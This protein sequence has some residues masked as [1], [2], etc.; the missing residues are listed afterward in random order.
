MPVFLSLFKKRISARL[1][2]RI[3]NLIEGSETRFLY[4]IGDL[5]STPKGGM[6]GKACRS[7]LLLGFLRIGSS[8]RH[9]C[10]TGM[11]YK[12]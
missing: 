9:P 1:L 8:S 6:Y 12:T 7:N 11:S 10:G 3:R 5:P 2:V 4:R